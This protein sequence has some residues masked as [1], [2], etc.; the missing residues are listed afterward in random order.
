MYTR[1]RQNVTCSISFENV[2]TGRLNFFTP[3]HM[4]M[5]DHESTALLFLGLKVRF[6]E[7]TDSQIGHL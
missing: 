6:S 7:F 5:N 2:H 4:F 3:V 1:R